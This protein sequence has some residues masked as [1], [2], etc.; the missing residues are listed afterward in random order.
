V[1]DLKVEA[2]HVKHIVHAEHLTFPAARVRTIPPTTMCAFAS[3]VLSVGCCL[4][5]PTPLP[6]MPPSFHDFDCQSAH[7]SPHDDVCD[8][9]VGGEHGLLR[10]GV[11]NGARGCRDRQ[12]AQVMTTVTTLVVWARCHW[13][14]VGAVSFV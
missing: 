10:S 14:C 1:L 4:T 3:R 8:E 13:F 12:S 9:G 5:C 6:S 11:E 7:H 2:P